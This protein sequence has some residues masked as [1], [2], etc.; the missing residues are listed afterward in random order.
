[1]NDNFHSRKSAMK[2]VRKLTI[3]NHSMNG[4]FYS[5]NFFSAKDQHKS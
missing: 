5:K 1:M 4:N 2:K 3:T